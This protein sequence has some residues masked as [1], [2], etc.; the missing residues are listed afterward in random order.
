MRLSPSLLAFSAALLAGCA[1]GPD[2]E[3]PASPDVKAYDSAPTAETT[4]D[5]SQKLEA[6]AD[7][8]ADWWQLFH[9]EAL[10]QLV[11]QS[12][13]DNPDLAAAQASLREAQDNE[14][15]GFAELFPTVNSSFAGTREKSGRAS[16]NG[17][18]PSQIY[19]LYNASV[20]VSYTFDL[21]G[22]TRR[23]IEELEAQTAMARYEVEAAYLSLT[24]NVVTAAIQE[25][26]LR[27]QV[28]AQQAIIDDQQKTLKILKARFEAG[29]VAKSAVAE[30]RAALASAQ[31]NLPPLQ[32][33]LVVTRHLLSVLA[34]QMPQQEPGAT[35]TLAGLTLPQSV[36]LSLPSKL[37]EQ[38]PDIRAAEEDLHAASAAIGVAEAMRL[39][40]ITLSADIGSMANLFSKLLTPGSGFWSL[41][42]SAAETLFDAGALAD[43]EDAAREAFNVSAANYRKTVLAAFQNVADTLH[44]LQSDAEV[45]NAK[46]E[47]ENAA[48]EGLYLAQVQFKSGAIGTADLLIA[49]QAEQQAK[50]ALVQARAQRYADTAALLTALGG[51]WWNRPAADESEGKESQ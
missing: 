45:L 9:N 47:G 26:G 13:K 8:P 5:N 4:A 17:G 6:G 38:R 20:G 11:A 10:S 21:F 16:S 22:G 42:G 43:K 19:N 37:V 30:Q 25:A 31:S 7:I 15:A 39:P 28:A 18:A 36:P 49:E 34:G 12:I 33:Q 29:A 23:G 46:I 35:F 14:S 51:G 50:L 32:H 24:G 3:K 2:F 40:Q 41:G 44:A 27:D 48:T 1:V